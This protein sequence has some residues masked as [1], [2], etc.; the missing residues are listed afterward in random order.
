VT[1]NFPSRYRYTGAAL[2]SDMAWL[3]GAAF[4]PLVA[5][6]VSSRFGLVALGIYLLSGALCTLAALGI[7]RAIETRD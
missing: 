3:V 6:G 5:L 2:S 7:N 1:S 4:A